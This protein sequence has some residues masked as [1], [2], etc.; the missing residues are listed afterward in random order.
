MKQTWIFR[1]L[2][3]QKSR[4]RLKDWLTKKSVPEWYLVL[5][6]F[7]C[8]GLNDCTGTGLQKS[9]TGSQGASCWNVQNKLDLTDERMWIFDDIFYAISSKNISSKTA[10]YN[11]QVKPQCTL[12]YST[13]EKK[14]Q[15]I[16]IVKQRLLIIYKKIWKLW[17]RK[18]QKCIF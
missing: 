5:V 2:D 1:D 17:H 3:F 7:Y 18:P 13:F 8:N 14:T 9:V 4:C 10:A 16:K 12:K 6:F 15:W 11:N